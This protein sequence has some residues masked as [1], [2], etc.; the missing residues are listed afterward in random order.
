MPQALTYA[1][2]SLDDRFMRFAIELPA[3]I[4]EFFYNGL[5]NKEISG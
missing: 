4:P 3:K 5:K 1:Q 2:K